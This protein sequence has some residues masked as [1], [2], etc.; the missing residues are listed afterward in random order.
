MYRQL[1]VL[2]GECDAIVHKDVHRLIRAKRLDTIDWYQ[3]RLALDRAMLKKL[4][5]F[6]QLAS[7]API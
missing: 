4:N 1:S 2:M 5:K 3:K 7:H 6:H